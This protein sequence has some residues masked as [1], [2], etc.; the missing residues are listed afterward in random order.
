MIDITAR[1]KTRCYATVDV[2]TCSLGAVY[3]VLIVEGV[4]MSRNLDQINDFPLESIGFPSLTAAQIDPNWVENGII[5]YAAS[6]NAPYVFSVLYA[7]GGIIDIP[8]NVMF[9]LPLS[10][11][12]TIL[13]F[14]RHTSTGRIVPFQCLQS[15]PA[16]ADPAL[17]SLPASE[18]LARA[19]PPRFDPILTPKLIAMLNEAQM[20]FM[21]IGILKVLDLQLMNPLLFGWSSA[22]SPSGPVANALERLAL[23]RGA[24]AVAKDAASVGERLVAEVANLQG[25][26]LQ[27]YLEFARRLS[28]ASGLTPRAKADLL[29]SLA[30][31]FGLDVGGQAAVSGGR[32]LVIAKDGKTAFQIAADGAIAFGRFNVATL[33]IAGATSIRPLQ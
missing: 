26:G 27:R 7:G 6:D 30:S 18:A 32:I 5:N 16:L 23:R 17:K 25:T 20:I 24:A 1:P 29:V 8:F 4:L 33:D 14:R 15:A 9:Y 10:N 19:V 28:L 22:A 13:L 2:P 12:G 11:S 3:S 21:A 31:R